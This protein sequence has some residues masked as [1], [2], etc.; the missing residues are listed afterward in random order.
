MYS[1]IKDFWKLRVGLAGPCLD[2]KSR[3]RIVR[4]E[5]LPAEFAR[6]VRFSDLGEACAKGVLPRVEE[7]EGQLYGVYLGHLPYTWRL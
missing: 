2:A 5:L 3:R 1:L 4:H 7:P 6:A